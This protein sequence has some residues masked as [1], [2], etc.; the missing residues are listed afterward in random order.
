[1][2]LKKL[3]PPHL[4]I[5]LLSISYILLLEWNIWFFVWVPQQTPIICAD[6]NVHFYIFARIN[7]RFHTLYQSIPGQL[8]RLDKP[9][10][11]KF[12]LRLSKFFKNALVLLNLLEEGLFPG[13]LSGILSNLLKKL[14]AKAYS[15]NIYYHWV[16]QFFQI[17]C[18]L[19]KTDKYPKAFGFRKE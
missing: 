4:T 1:M 17:F 7:C 18:L 6:V 9:T 12:F 8:Q 2:K 10:W 5:W 3:V 19:I 14:Y 16:F 11:L 15:L 13:K